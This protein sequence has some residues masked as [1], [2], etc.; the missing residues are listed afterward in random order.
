MAKITIENLRG[1]LS[2]AIDRDLEDNQFSLLTDFTY[3]TKQR[4]RTTPGYKEFGNQIGADP[5]T[6]LFFHK[7]D[8]G[9]RL[10]LATEGTNLRKY[11]E[12]TGDF[13]VVANWLTAYD[14]KETLHMLESNIESG[15]WSVADD[16]SGL[17]FSS[18]DTAQGAGSLDFFA[19]ASGL[20]T[21]ATVV[22]STLSPQI[23]LTNYD[24]TG[25][26]RMWVKL[27][28]TTGI[29]GFRLR[30][31]NDASNYWEK[32]T[33]V[34]VGGGAIVAN[35]WM[36]I[37]FDWSSATETGTVD[38]STI[39]YL[40]FSIT[41][42]GTFPGHTPDG[43]G[44][45]NE[46]PFRIDEIAV[47]PTD[48]LA[49]PI[50]SR[51]DF[52]VYEG[53]VGIVNGIDPYMIYDVQQNSLAPDAGPQG[54]Q[55]EYLQDRL[56][57][58]GDRNFPNRVYY[59]AARPNNLD[60]SNFTN[61]IDVGADD[62]VGVNVLREIGSSI[63]VGKDG[64]TYNLDV[65]NTSSQTLN[66]LEGMFGHRTVRSVGNALVY[67]SKRGL[68]ELRSLDGVSSGQAIETDILSENVEELVQQVS[69]Q[70]RK[71]SSGFYVRASA[72]YY[73]TFDAD[74]DGVPETT[75]IY[76]ASPKIRAFTKRNFPPI[77]DY[78]EYEKSDGEIIYLFASAAGGQ[79]YQFETGIADDDIKI[80][81]E[82]QHKA[83]D[84]GAPELQ[85]D[86]HEIYFVGEK[87]EGGEIDVEIYVDEFLV[88][89]ATINDDFA[90]TVTQSSSIG[91]DAIG[92]GTIGGGTTEFDQK[93]SVTLPIHFTG[94]TITVKMKSGATVTSFSPQRMTIVYEPQDLSLYP[95][96]NI[97]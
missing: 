14:V 5:V 34:Q 86:F 94:E 61:A 3:D 21:L 6:S 24:E 7:F 88:Q 77:Y 32:T 42:D 40:H 95:F 35:T 36:F 41:Y 90:R 8:D 1:G 37:E 44:G 13:D 30:W 10:L 83:W 92:T 49:S 38:P 84:F 23:D 68:E 71:L 67:Q 31:G 52:A 97:L 22:N 16:A 93:Y 69:A 58:G 43:G 12:G 25:L 26:I 76:N 56:F 29:T 60:G 20:T 62:T 4:L 75:L 57:M 39:D 2:T 18:S 53:G 66:S 79:V 70:Y 17:S 9:T 50:R 55:I 80:D 85:K 96:S 63:I 91:Q 65:A 15:T 59:T 64:K 51:C 82:L 78:T 72:N 45:Y 87:N 73:Y 89:E 74:G 33:T 19:P 81:C 47:Y 28:T 11:N 46:D 48:N 27:F 54:D